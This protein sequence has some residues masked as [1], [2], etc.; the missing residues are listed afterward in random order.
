M[1]YNLSFQS[2]F[3]SE[4]G[5]AFE[6]LRLLGITNGEYSFQVNQSFLG[7]LLNKNIFFL[8]KNIPTKIKQLVVV[9]Q[10][11][12][13]TDEWNIVES[14]KKTFLRISFLILFSL[15]S[16][17]TNLDEKCFFSASTVHLSSS[18]PCKESINE[19]TGFI[20]KLLL[21]SPHILFEA[22]GFD[23]EKRL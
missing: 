14:K 1:K 9:S 20:L 17:S 3:T 22:G 21:D 8:Q 18:F 11:W 7:F 12:L 16:L 2:D 15:Y 5:T 23:L 6:M 4:W 19:T 10:L 13:Q